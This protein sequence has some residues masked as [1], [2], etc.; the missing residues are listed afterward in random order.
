MK[1]QQNKDP[2]SYWTTGEKGIRCW[3]RLGARRAHAERLEAIP[4]CEDREAISAAFRE[5][6][7]TNL[8][9]EAIRALDAG[10]TVMRGGGMFI[11]LPASRTP[12]EAP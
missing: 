3:M 10:Y 8:W 4:L 5:Y 6:R 1:E 12:K 11:F 2:D 7:V 9:A